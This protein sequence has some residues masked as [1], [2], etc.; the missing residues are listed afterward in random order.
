VETNHTYNIRSAVVN[1]VSEVFDLLLSIEIEHLAALSQSHFYGEKMLA[2]IYRVG[3]VAGMVTFQVDAAYT[4]ILAG[5]ML[6][7]DPAEL[8][9]SADVKGVLTEVC[10]RVAGN[11]KS[12]LCDAGLTCDLPLPTHIAGR[13][14]RTGIQP[15]DRQE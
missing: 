12:G 1:A 15:A 6:D 4:R 11:L 5:N 9:N 3:S 2:A 13:D 7:T 10:N 14:Y 8:Q